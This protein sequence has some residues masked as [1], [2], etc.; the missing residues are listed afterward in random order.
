M[1][2]KGTRSP[3]YPIFGVEMAIERLETFYKVEG[4]ATVPKDVAVKAWG[5][6]TT[7]GP[8]LQTVST[9]IQYG[10][11]DKIGGKNLK[12]TE[13]GMDII[14]PQN[15][16]DKDKAI[17]EASQNPPIF[18]EILKHFGKDLP[19]DDTLKAY[20]VRRTPTGYT[21][22]A[23]KTVIKS[24]RDTL[25]FTNLL[26]KEYNDKVE[27]IEIGDLVN[28]ESQGVL[29]FPE[30]KQVKG[31]SDCGQWVFTEGSETGLPIQEIKLVRK[32][33][34]MDTLAAQERQTNQT[35]PPRNPY[36]QPQSTGPSLSM[37]IFRDNHI[38]IKLKK[39][40]SKEEWKTIRE[41]IFDF[42]EN[43]FVESEDVN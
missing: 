21:E 7:S 42:S 19:S 11:L 14:H 8:A 34:T 32:A 43:T 9:M 2:K 31:F 5:Y 17:Q 41:K 38:D 16:P 15:K 28:W 33:N 35:Q 36:F 26:H 4:K 22:T 25:D 40:V 29:Q 1:A 12:I 20:L 23:T 37:D 13:R 27:K 3:K 18:A 6:T 39:K 10:L 30:P 24:F